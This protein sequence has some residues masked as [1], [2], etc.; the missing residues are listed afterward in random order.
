MSINFS[1]LQLIIQKSQEIERLHQLQQQQ[2]RVQ[3]QQ[4][5]R[6]LDD[7]ASQKREQI[8]KDE[9]AD[10]VRLM[11]RQARQQAK[12]EKE[13]KDKR[14]E[15][16]IKKQAINKKNVSLPSDHVIDIKL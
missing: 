11:D 2:S 1:D 4:F 14:K 6:M 13:K 5:S 12:D 9:Q 3:Q 16:R 15:D 7:E 10:Q 8:E